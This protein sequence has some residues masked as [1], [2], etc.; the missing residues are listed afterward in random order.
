MKRCELPE[1][2]VSALVDGELESTDVVATA[3]HLIDCPSCRDFYRK[4]RALSDLVLEAEL[5]RDLEPAPE[6]VWR[7]I[8]S[9]RA[10]KIG[11]PA[12]AGWRRWAPRVA[13]VLLLG[14]AV[15]LLTQAPRTLRAGSGDVVE[16]V[17]EQDPG[18]MS[19]ARF[20]EV[21]KEVLEADRRYHRKMLEV[22]QA[23]T[24]S[25]PGHEGAFE[26]G[27]GDAQETADGPGEGTPAELVRHNDRL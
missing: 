10:R 23:A 14:V 12:R 17:L 1:T 26:G 5:P 11:R 25:W 6:A 20:I 21:L 3:D 2:S 24:E 13:A 15:W 18:R 22:M 4:A 27:L 7:R 8:E 19:E 9:Q 16:V